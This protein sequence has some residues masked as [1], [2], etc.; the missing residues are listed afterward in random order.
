M[1]PVRLAD[2]QAGHGGRLGGVLRGT[3][4]VLALGWRLGH[5]ARRA[6]YASGLV[7]SRVLDVPVLSVGNL[8]AG[9]TGKTPFVAWVARML[10]ENGHR[11]GIL[12]RGYGP[13]SAHH[14]RSD[15]GAVLAA[16]LGRDVPQ[17]EDPSRVRGAARLLAAHPETDVLLLDDGFQHWRVARDLDLVL[18]DATCP[19]GHGHL[20]PR[21]TLREEPRALRRAGVVVLTRT[22]RVGTDALAALRER[23]GALVAAPV[24]EA[25]TVARA[26]RR[27]GREETPSVLRGR[28]VVAACGI[29][30]PEA[31][32]ALVEDAGARILRRVPLADHADPGPA[33]WASL[34][35]EARAAGEDA[36]VVT[37][38]KD[39]V[40]IREPGP[41]A[42]LEIALE[43]TRGEEILRERILE[44]ARRGRGS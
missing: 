17:V 13:R 25:R 40:K 7:R 15:E 31:F 9:G 41:I 39:V 20:L 2:I 6:A 44:A 28:S 3:L 34:V 19:F 10:L 38:G 35:E 8:V 18:L 5:G 16:L 37:T 21:G 22:E 24:V 30:N 33:F 26:L 1:R 23:V 14:G 12:A 36:I 11:P 29:G 43:V 4:S 32:F 27:G 42:A